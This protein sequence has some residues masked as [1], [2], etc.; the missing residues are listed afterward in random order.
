MWVAYKRLA[1]RTYSAE[2]DDYVRD[3]PYPAF[4]RLR[5]NTRRVS[6]EDAFSVMRDRFQGTPY[7]LEDG[8]SGGAF[9]SPARWRAGKGES[10]IPD[11]FWERS[12]AT[13][14][15]IVS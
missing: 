7:S 8:L 6:V 13:W 11:G 10:A 1:N 2:Y 9:G 12:I 15:T 3:A 5:D 14:K 4:V